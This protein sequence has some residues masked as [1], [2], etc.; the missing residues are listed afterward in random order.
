MD[1]EKIVRIWIGND[2][3]EWIYDE[4]DWKQFKGMNEDEIYEQIVLDVYNNIS[5]EIL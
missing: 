3:V 2:Y 1:V 4:E 5:I